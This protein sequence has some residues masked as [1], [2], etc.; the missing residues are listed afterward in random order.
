MTSGFLA[1]RGALERVFT[2]WQRFLSSLIVLLTIEAALALVIRVRVLS[3]LMSGTGTLTWL[4]AV[5]SVGLLLLPLIVYAIVRART[6][7][8]ELHL[9][10]HSEQETANASRTL[11]DTTTEG[12]YAVDADG[13]CTMAN[14]AAGVCLGY[15]P[16]E[17]VDRNMHDLIHHT[18]RDGSAYPVEE[19]P[20]HLARSQRE[21]ITVE[22]DVFWKKDGSSFSTAY[23]SAPI[24]NDG[25]V[26]GAVV[27]F[28][29][30]EERKQME[31]SVRVAEEHTRRFLEDLPVAVFVVDDQGRPTYSNRMSV[32]LLGL[33]EDP[34]LDSEQISSAY[35]VYVAGTDRPYDN[36]QLPVLRAL[37][38]E[39]MTIDDMEVHKPDG[40]VVPLEVW[41]GPIR[42]DAGNVTNAV[43]VFTDVTERKKVEERLR[44]ATE[45]ADKANRAKS[46]FLS[47]MSHELRTPLNAILGFA[48]LLQLDE[49][50]PEQRDSVEEIARGGAH[51][52]SLI[53]EILDLST[54]EAGRLDLTFEEVD[55][56]ELSREVVSSLRPMAEE[57]RITLAVQDDADRE[58]RW[59][60]YA[61]RQRVKQVLLNL[62]TNGIKYNEPNGSVEISFGSSNDNLT[63]AVRDTGPGITEDN[64]EKLFAPFERLGAETSQVEGTGLGLALTR[65]LVE[66]MGGS[67]SVTSVLGKGSEFCVTFPVAAVDGGRDIWQQA[68]DTEKFHVLYI[69]DNES[70][71]RL[72]HAAIGQDECLQLTATAT[73][74]AGLAL[75]RSLQ[76]DVILLDLQLPDID[77]SEVFGSL[78]VDPDTASIPVVIVTAAYRE[79][80]R[81]FFMRSGA[82]AFLKKPIDV[83]EVLGLLRRIRDSS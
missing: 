79:S 29:N 25:E 23:S 77:G 34:S 40:S 15:S 71:V 7:Q 43:A 18:R 66:T 8:K 32:E 14:R 35:Q 1:G 54:I 31:R 28:R 4:E 53:N 81:S 19:C 51:L 49:L 39:T 50:A 78:L 33:P 38:G 21:T 56:G 27:S 69:D 37:S 24:I 16:E 22:D 60:A 61:D 76:P 46:D 11:L 72:L 17:L 41:G 52:L 68:A 20:I 12:I 80:E 62:V 13:L 5:S 74:N 82:K 30:I 10:V 42:D 45:A 3:G 55:V 70:D 6:A 75:A 63:I 47:R 48:Q 57:K 2:R 58:H 73:G 65:R 64:M 59:V 44:E 67:L 36:D 83:S 9:L 26:T